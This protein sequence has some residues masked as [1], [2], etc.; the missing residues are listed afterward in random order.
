MTREEKDQIINKIAEKL[1]AY[2]NFYITDTSKLTSDKTSALRRLCFS[3]GVKIYV[4]KNS[5]IRKAMEK[6]GNAAYEPLFESLKGTTAIMF[7][8]TGNI[9]G[10]LIKEFRKKNEKPLL[11]SAYIDTA[12]FIG[13]NQLDALASIKSKNELVGEIIGLL[14]S[15]ARNVIA[16]LQSGGGKIAGIVKT[17]S[18]RPE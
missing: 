16:A 15:P 9:P 12:V 11:K 17:L 1:A 3:K 6:S 14:Q 8:E 13:D 7:S 10:K 4:A 18:E 5:L 2:P